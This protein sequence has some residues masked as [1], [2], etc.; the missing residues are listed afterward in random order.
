MR[1]NL[2]TRSSLTFLLVIV[3][4]GES[5]YSEN[6]RI[7]N[8]KIITMDDDN[9]TANTLLISG[10]RIVSVGNGGGA[11]NGNDGLGQ[12]TIID[13]MGRVVIP[14]IIDQH[15]HWNRSAIM[16]GHAL[17][18]GENV[19]TLEGLEDAIKARAEEVPAGEWITLIGRHNHLQFLADPN[20]PLSG[21]YPTR[22]ELDR[23]APDHKVLFSQR[24][25]PTPIGTDPSDFNRARFSGLGQMNTSARDFFNAM[26]PPVPFVNTIPVDGVLNDAL[27]QQVYEWTRA[28][29]TL[30]DQVRSE[31]HARGPGEEHY[32]SH[33]LVS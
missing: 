6:I 2:L 28:N 31:Q 12:V 19:F 16:W 23:W 20:T 17:H 7:V 3:F 8:A 9:P 4:T 13:A 29:N 22:Q 25:T 33:T 30:E 15:L 10:N 5:V 26:A 27:N 18:R 1:T 14:G 11:G 32:R 24:F 21:R